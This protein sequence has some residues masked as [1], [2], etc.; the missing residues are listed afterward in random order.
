M[1]FRASNPG[2]WILPLLVG[3]AAA[4]VLVSGLVIGSGSQTAA[5]ASTGTR[6]SCPVPLTGVSILGPSRGKPGELYT[7][8]ASLAPITAT[9][10]VTIT[11]WPE[12]GTGQGTAAASYQWAEAGMYS[13]TL[14]A[15]NCGGM[16]SD[17][18]TI[19][20]STGTWLHL[21]G[22]FRG[23]LPTA[24]SD[25]RIVEILYSECDERIQFENCGD[26][27]QD[28]T[29]WQIQSVVEDQWYTF[30]G[31]YVLNAGAVVYVHSGPESAS[32]PP[33]HLQW[34]LDYK[35]RNAGD[36]AVLYDDA[37]QVVDTYCYGDACP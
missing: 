4:F 1:S 6:A 14:E 21:P 13:L 7:V 33:A 16:V 22:V 10:P 30:P 32:S 28:M 2:R 20:I 23:S 31:G 26:A 35:W 18:H 17:T 27:S 29:G 25:L 15:E 19:V 37:G 36:E 5:Q 11:W 12:P 3:V 34:D 9:K 8:T 24:R